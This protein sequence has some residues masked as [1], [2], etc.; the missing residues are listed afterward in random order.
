M[1]FSNMPTKDYCKIGSLQGIM[2]FP[3]LCKCITQKFRAQLSLK[4][5]QDCAWVCDNSGRVGQG[6]EQ[7]ALME[8]VPAHGGELEQDDLWSPIQPRPSN[9]DHDSMILWSPVC[10]IRIDWGE[11]IRIQA[12]LRQGTEQLIDTPHIF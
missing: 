11:G 1:E 7:P 2:S 4:V 3:T 5:L 8:V 9:S 10:F 12:S 6:S